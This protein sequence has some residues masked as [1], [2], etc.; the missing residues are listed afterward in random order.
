[1]DADSDIPA[2]EKM[3]EDLDLPGGEEKE[4]G[5]QGLKKNNHHLNVKDTTKNA[6]EDQ[7]N[8]L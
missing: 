4:M 1:M 7:G 2:P 3:N 6:N 8:Y 5:M